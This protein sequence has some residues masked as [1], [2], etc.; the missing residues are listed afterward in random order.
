MSGCSLD[1][2]L[3][4]KNATDLPSTSPETFVIENGAE[5]TN[6]TSL[7]LQL[8][9]SGYTEMQI[10]EGS[11]CSDGGSWEVFNNARTFSL[12][13][14]AEGRKVLSARF[15]KADGAISGCSSQSIIL[16]VTAP[17]APSGASIA[18]PYTQPL[19]SFV[20]GSDTLSGVRKNQIRVVNEI[21]SEVIND[22]ID[23]ENPGIG[24]LFNSANWQHSSYV[25]EFK[26]IDKAG[27]SST[28]IKRLINPRSSG[29]LSAGYAHNC[30][31][32]RS[33]TKVKCW[34]NNPYGNLGLGHADNIGDDPN[35]MATVNGLSFGSDKIVQVTSGNQHNCILTESGKVKCWGR[36]A[37]GQLGYEN[38]NDLGDQPNELQNLADV[39]LPEPMV[40]LSAGDFHTC[41]LSITGKVRCWGWGGWG[42][43]GNGGTSKGS[44]VGSM[45][46]LHI[47]DFGAG[48]K[49]LR[50][51]SGNTHN[52][53]LID[54]GQVMCW[55]ENSYGELG[56]NNS[57][58]VSGNPTTAVQLSASDK[59]VDI[60][61]GI[62]FSCALLE[63]GTVKCWGRNDVGQL[64]LGTTSNIGHTTGSMAT[65]NTIDFGTTTKVTKLFSGRSRS[66]A[67]F[68]NNSVRCW[69]KTDVIGTVGSQAGSVA[70]SSA[71]TL[72]GGKIPNQI[73]HGD[74][75]ICIRY[76]DD[77]VQCIGTQNRGN[78]GY[79]SPHNI[80]GINSVEASGKI[81]LGLPL[82]SPANATD[83]V[84][85]TN[86][87]NKCAIL[88]NGKIK[89]WGTQDAG[90]M[91]DTPAT[92]SAIGETVGSIVASSFL[93]LGASLTFKSISGSSSSYCAIT[94]TDQVK[95]WGENS[96]GQT[97]YDNTD[98][99]G[100]GLTTESRN[101]FLNLPSTIKQLWTSAANCA[102]Q[103][104]DLLACWGLDWATQSYGIGSSPGSM[105]TITPFTLPDLISFSNGK[106][107]THA[108][109]IFTNA[110]SFQTLHCWGKS[111]TGA[112]ATSDGT[113]QKSATPVNPVDFGSASVLKVGVA[114]EKT[115]V[116]LSDNSV[117]CFGKGDRGQNG[118]G[119]TG[120]VGLSAADFPTKSKVSM[121]PAAET[122]IDLYVG[123][124]KVCVKT[125]SGKLYCWGETWTGDLGTGLLSQYLGDSPSD[126][127]LVKPVS[128][129]W[130]PTDVDV[131][132]NI[133]ASKSN[134]ELYCWGSNV[135]RIGHE[136]NPTVNHVG[137]AL[138]Y[139][140]ENAAIP[141][142]LTD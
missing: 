109:G 54:D 9:V 32:S 3:L 139:R 83:R 85:A 136:K 67:I 35:E 92:N 81:P 39:S 34:G 73:A 5:F 24:T 26:T 60:S 27:N 63:A 62:Y 97:G 135:R 126:I 99:Y 110:S 44:T 114:L 19:V 88:N 8:N 1:V 13:D 121:I 30:A 36:S 89:C 70:S 80:D 53:A 47:L 118:N 71:L 50:I 127:N 106:G 91:G 14:T 125:S 16:D 58:W 120:N 28:N 78:L 37:D 124:N 141:L 20:S 103:T 123:E 49:A 46:T 41:S 74:T 131:D 7:S 33:N 77:S 138:D 10:T 38:T 130:V 4:T 82:L 12:T 108:C 134:G 2:S 112:L 56:I 61:A 69:G 25:F 87:L 104:N 51:A 102:L 17:S 105:A 65:L 55:G 22:W 64:G 111:T 6:K 42:Q 93:D 116:L 15:R 132:D 128:I 90:S 43:L 18:N 140:I 79:N 40:Q 11:T 48:K 76:T 31:I 23:I 113:T 66:C 21:T 107:S 68:D 122:P 86:K 133:C 137:I 101:S 100:N 96:N 129:S 52:C 75:H 115:C 142:I 94:N 59:V 57:V 29:V 119:L 98:T 45:S 95:C 72:P 117:H 84:F